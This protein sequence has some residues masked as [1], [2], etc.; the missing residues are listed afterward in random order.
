MD[1]KEAYTVLEAT[2]SLE[3]NVPLCKQSNVMKD[4]FIS[5]MFT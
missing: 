3:L 5:I 1:L 4:L 2:V